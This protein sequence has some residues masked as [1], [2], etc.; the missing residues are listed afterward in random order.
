MGLLDEFGLKESL[1]RRPPE[2]MRELM[3]CIEEYKWLEDDRLQ[4][5][6]KAPVINYPRNIGFQPRPWKD[7]SIQESGPRVGEV[8]VAFKEPV[9]RI[10]DRIKNEPYFKWPNEMPS[11]PSRRNHNLYCTYHKDK[12]HTT[13]QCRVLK[14]HLEELVKAGHLKEFVVVTRNQKAGQADRLHG[15][16]TPVGSNRSHPCSSKRAFQRL[17]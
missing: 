11:K 12:G 4:N 13:E 7:L 8:N 2:D 15:T 14:E 3:R 9:H 5:K 1:T 17:G 6:R 10:V 16:P